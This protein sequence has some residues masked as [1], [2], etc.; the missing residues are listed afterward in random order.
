M[1]TKHIA[2]FV[3]AVLLCGVVCIK[4]NG[5]S[6]SDFDVETTR[7]DKTVNTAEL[8]KVA[9]KYFYAG[10]ESEDLN[11]REAYLSR[12]LE[13]YM[14]LLKQNPTDV[15]TCTQIAVIHDNL[16]H[17]RLAKTYFIRAVNL[18]NLNPFANFYYGEYYFVKREYQ[19]ALRYYLTAYNN[20]YKDS[21][22]V[23]LR[24]ATIYEKLGDIAK[25]KNYYI[26]AGKQNPQQEGLKEK[27]ELLEKIYYSKSDYQ[28]N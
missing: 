22:P 15:T 1:Q 16:N 23:N 12:A 21:F 7:N 19:K 13:K 3:F 6:D 24:L 14:L 5:A 18:E 28:R 4:A 8:E 17:P 9:D 10:L 26:E 25:A 2:S 11:K 27:I 20:G